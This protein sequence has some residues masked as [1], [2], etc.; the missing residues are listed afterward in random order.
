MKQNISFK[1]GKALLFSCL[2]L[3][4]IAFAS[5]GSSD[6]ESTSKSD[7]TVS[8]AKASTPEVKLDGNTLTYGDHVYTVNGEID[9]KASSHKTPTASVTF[10]NIPADYNEF[11]TVYNTLLG[12]SPQGAAAMIPMAIEIFA[13]DNAVGENCFKLLC[14]S[15]STVSD[16]VRVLKTKLEASQYG[17]ENDQYLQRYMAAALLKGADNKN[18]YTPVEPYTVEMCSSPNGIKDAPLTGGTV[19][20]LYIL[21]NGWDTFQ[22]S[23]EIM[24]PNNSELY[25]VFNCPATYAQCKTIVGTW[26]GLK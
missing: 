2:G 11:E 16:L 12:K 14:N 22:R 9:F 20:Y 26:P 6:E 21:A 13:R 18:A 10:T 5:C 3:G 23:V 24:Q 19:Y 8:T 17:P 4:L 25:K 15:P 1:I 7:T